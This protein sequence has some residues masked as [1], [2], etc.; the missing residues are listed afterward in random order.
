MKKLNMSKNY[1]FLKFLTKT[2]DR[3][4]KDDSRVITREHGKRGYRMVERTRRRFGR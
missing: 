4:I 3:S 1:L 2:T